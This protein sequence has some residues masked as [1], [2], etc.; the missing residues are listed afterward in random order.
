MNVRKYLKQSACRKI[1]ETPVEK[2][3]VKDN[4]EDAEVSKQTFYRYYSD[5]YALANELYFELTQKDII[6]AF[7]V[8]MRVIGEQCTADI[9]D[10]EMVE[11]FHLIIPHIL[12]PSY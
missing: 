7:R 1:I 5:K 4:L 8:K 11:R 3:T 9:D 2:L 12:V 6:D 10:E